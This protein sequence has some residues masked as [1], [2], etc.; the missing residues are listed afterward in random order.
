[1]KTSRVCLH[2]DSSVDLPHRRES[3]C[4][5]AVDREIRAVQAYLRSL[6]RRKTHLLQLHRDRVVAA[7]RR[8]R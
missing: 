6:T 4:F 3:D 8:L 1:M 7:R 2:C 5:R